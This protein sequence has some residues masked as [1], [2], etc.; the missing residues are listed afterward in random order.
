MATLFSAYV[1]VVAVMQRSIQFD[2]YGVNVF[3]LVLVYMLGGLFGGAVVGALRPLNGTA[4][5]GALIGA[6]GS[7]PFWSG[8][9]TILIG[10]PT[11]W[12]TG[13]WVV[14]AILAGLAALFGVHLA[15]KE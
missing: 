3:Q 1:V 13:E 15:T 10:P 11:R 4:A 2:A 7:I 5:G 12:D 8:T 14:L 9:L 6:L